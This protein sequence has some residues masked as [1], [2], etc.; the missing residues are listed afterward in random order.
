MEW[1]VLADI[2]NRIGLEMAHHVTAAGVL[3]E[4]A[5]HAPLYRGITVDEIGG[6][7]VRWPEREQSRTGAAEV[8]GGLSFSDPEEPLGAP[9]PHDGELRLATARD[10]WAAPEIEH[11]PSLE[12]L[13]PRQRLML[14]P[15][16]A[17]LLGI[18]RGDPVRVASNGTILETEASPREAV[19]RG[20]CHLIERTAEH[21][22]NVLMN[23]GPVLVRVYKPSS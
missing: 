2:G 1:E 19:K 12:F 3:T 13:R 9:P 18:R 11:S 4:I 7:G 22:P 10:I 14:N 21:N 20:T 8:I 15:A 17:D 23:G 5:E 6:R 16:D